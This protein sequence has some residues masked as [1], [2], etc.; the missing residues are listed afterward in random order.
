MGE[1]KEKIGGPS[2]WAQVQMLI[3]NKDYIMLLNNNIIHCTLISILAGNIS[4]LLVV[5]GFNNSVKIQ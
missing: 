2:V 1:A 4:P 5:N 3:G